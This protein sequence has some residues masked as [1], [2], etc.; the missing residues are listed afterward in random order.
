ML[1]VIGIIANFARLY[2]R[3]GNEEMRND[4]LEVVEQ[5]E[6]FEAGLTQNLE[7]YLCFTKSPREKLWEPCNYQTRKRSLLFVP[8]WWTSS[9][10]IPHPSTPTQFNLHVDEVEQHIYLI[11]GNKKFHELDYVHQKEWDEIQDGHRRRIAE[12]K[13][14]KWGRLR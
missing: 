9:Q 7:D 10:G 4:E 14:E 2:R 1:I 6:S 12:Y 3:A 13:H 5:F 8:K 11:Y